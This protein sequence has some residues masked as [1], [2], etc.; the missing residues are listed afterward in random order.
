M[1]KGQIKN[2]YQQLK[3]KRKG[4]FIGD[5][6]IARS[7]M[8]CLPEIFLEPWNENAESD[9][10]II[11]EN[12]EN[13][14]ENDS[15]TADDHRIALNDFVQIMDIQ[16]EVG[17][18]RK[19]VYWGCG[20][21]LDMQFDALRKI[22]P[23]EFIIDMVK[24]GEYRKVPIRKFN[25]S[26]TRENYFVIITS[27]RY[28]QEIREILIEAGYQEHQDFDEYKMLLLMGGSS[29]MFLKTVRGKRMKHCSCIRPFDY[30][31]VGVGG[32]V[33]HCCFQWLPYYVGNILNVEINSLDTIKSRIVRLS[34][35]NETYSFCNTLLCP[36]MNKDRKEL[37]SDEIRIEEL[38]DIPFHITKAD[39]AFDNTCNLYCVSCREQV[40]VEC[41]NEIMEI[42]SRIQE[43]LLPQLNWL[44]V[45]GNGEA[46]FS[47]A[48]KKL[49][50]EEKWDNLNLSILSN[51]NL[52]NLEKWKEIEGK[53]KSIALYFSID[54]ATEKTYQIVRRGGNWQRLM[55]NLK[56]ASDLRKNGSVCDF[57]LRFVV[58][59]TNYKEIPAFVRLGNAL[60][61]DQID[62]SRIENWG[63]YTEEEFRRVSM[64]NGD[65]MKS[66]L[67]EVM[68]D[69]VMESPNVCLIN[70]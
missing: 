20:S 2:F 69:S 23:P 29:E 26:I 52:F 61:V 48:Y 44:T 65:K 16:R 59:S 68:N 33:T 58:S 11:E 7:L 13:C 49:L 19:Y 27:L 51:G 38:L 43:E 64:F 14:S 9:A 17:G 45:A 34:F 62:F 40:L 42:A 8:Y 31:N 18:E 30:I 63:T 32:Y 1:N 53:F 28:K 35:L 67:K 21:E 54:A 25:Y 57:R 22:Y 5:F 41:G 39:M 46:F 6:V 37:Y 55:D 4:Y 24:E 10:Y 50:T 12:S 66:E 15:R 60:G 70:L 47:K 3:N 36:M 56:F